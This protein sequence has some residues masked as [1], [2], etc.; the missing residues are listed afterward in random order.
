M[1]WWKEEVVAAAEVRDKCGASD[2][3]V[4]GDECEGVED[5]DDEP[6]AALGA[7]APRDSLPRLSP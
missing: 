7:R 6:S 2:E 5:E 1:G 4:E 3:E